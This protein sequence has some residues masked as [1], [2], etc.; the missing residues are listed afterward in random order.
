M[1]SS[2]L[3]RFSQQEQNISTGRDFKRKKV[4][5]LP[6]KG[7]VLHQQCPCVRDK[8]HVCVLIANFPICR[9]YILIANFLG[10]ALLPFF[11]LALLNFRLY[12]TIKETH[13]EQ[14]FNVF[15]RQEQK[16]FSEF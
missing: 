7:K 10:M 9:D 12:T 15:C 5:V 13:G 2:F 3:I 6:Q 11:L 8:I 1:L 14:R 4:Y 16:I